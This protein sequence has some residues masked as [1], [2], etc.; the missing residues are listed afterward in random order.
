MA[1]EK[2]KLNEKNYLNYV[3]EGKGQKPIEAQS[4]IYKLILLYFLLSLTF[5]THQLLFSASWLGNSFASLLMINTAFSKGLMPLPY[6]QAY[7]LVNSA[8]KY[9]MMAV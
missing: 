7:T 4:Y 9:K 3:R 5:A 8:P 1:T 6:F 2:R